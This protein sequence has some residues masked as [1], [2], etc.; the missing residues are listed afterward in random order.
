MPYPTTLR[1]ILAL[2]LLVLLAMGGPAWA[3]VETDLSA[4]GAD[5]AK[6]PATPPDAVAA[7][8]EQVALAKLF[9]EAEQLYKDKK[10]AEALAKYNEVLQQAP[11]N[12]TSLY[13]VACCQAML[14][15]KAEAVA[16]LQQAVDAGFLFF[17]QLVNEPALKPLLDEK[18]VKDILADKEKRF[19]A[20]ADQRVSIYKGQFP[21][22]RV[23]KDDP[24]RLII[25]TSLP[26]K[27]LAQLQGLL[28]AVA[29]S[30]AADFFTHRPQIYVGLL[31]P[32]SAAE[33]AGLGLRP[34]TAGN[35]NPQNRSLLINLGT[36]TGTMTHEFTHALHFA[37]MEERGQQHPMWVV[38]GLGSLYE[39]CT[40]RGGHMVGLVNWRLIVL[41]QAIA[42]QKTLPLAAFLADSS[43]EFARNSP[44]SY[45]T[46]RY[47]MLLLQ[48]KG[49]LKDW[50]AQYCA[51][52]EQDPTGVKTLEKLYGKPLAEFEKD[53]YAFVE[54]LE[55]KMPG[56]PPA[57]SPAPAPEAPR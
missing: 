9:Q 3:R 18:G 15:K 12:Y 49:L 20:N 43:A 13:R 33:L 42:Q 8:A 55:F 16:A 29:D 4:A 25:A 50:Y 35:Y 38:E 5:V 32:G 14:G 34:G 6:P 28:H 44:V 10:A 17:A 1:P 53:L 30:L 56:P 21:A 47:V 46:A 51:G 23:L 41:K 52:F 39:Q 37:D 19:Q 27:E 57:P 24:Y 54:P 31:I 48:E 2:A 7:K 22:Y 11:G 40:L 36:G 26:E 45:A